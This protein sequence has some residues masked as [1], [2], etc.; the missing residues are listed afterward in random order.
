MPSVLFSLTHPS[1]RQ[2]QLVGPRGERIRSMKPRAMV[3]LVRAAIGEL[4]ESLK[5][6]TLALEK[7]HDALEQ[8]AVQC[9]ADAQVLAEFGRQGTVRDRHLQIAW[10]AR[11]Q[12]S[13]SA[14]STKD[15]KQGRRRITPELVVVAVASDVE[16]E[17]KQTV[18]K[19]FNAEQEAQEGHESAADSSGDEGHDE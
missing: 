6:G 18:D 10:R 3:Q 15:G 11:Q 1:L 9:L 14:A 5:L 2:P 16:T 4:D 8:Q 13:G 7:V 12:S 17:Q 19:S